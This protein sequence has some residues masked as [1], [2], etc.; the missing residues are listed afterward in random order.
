M[1]KVF[2][3]IYVV[4][5]DTTIDSDFFQNNMVIASDQ[6]LDLK[7]TYDLNLKDAI[8]LT[9]DYSPVDSLVDSTIALVTK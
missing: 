3:Y 7:N 2:K 6:K 4:P 1:K 5:C 8:I 9:D